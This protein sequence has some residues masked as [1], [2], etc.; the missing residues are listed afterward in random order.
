MSKSG[1]READASVLYDLD[2]KEKD[3]NKLLLS[4]MENY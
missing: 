3:L 2:Q 4:G 1:D